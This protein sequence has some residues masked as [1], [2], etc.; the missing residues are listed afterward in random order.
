MRWLTSWFSRPPPLPPPES[1]ARPPWVDELLMEVRTQREPDPVADDEA[2]GLAPAWASELREAIQKHSRA[3]A[4][5]NA[6]L[7]G[8]FGELEAHLIALKRALQARP[9][10]PSSERYDDLFDALD[11]LDEAQRIST[12]PHLR[13]GLSRITKRLV[14]FCERAGYA[15]ITPHGEA[16]DARFVQVVGVERSE[17]VLPGRVTRVVRAAIVADSQLVREGSVIVSGEEEGHG[18][19]L[20]N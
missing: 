8:M 5:Q 20:G 19:R 1:D 7:E 17:Q 18:Q 16:P 13:E 3:A 9:S 15:R 14:G 6:R 10:T 2:D 11:G 12:E 4:K